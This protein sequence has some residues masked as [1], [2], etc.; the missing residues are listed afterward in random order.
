MQLRFFLPDHADRTTGGHAYD[1]RMVEAL[2]RMG[3]DAAIVPV[4][5]RLPLAD[6]AACDAAAAA[7]RDCPSPCIRVIDGS[8]LAAF[9]PL[10]DALGATQMAGLIHHPTSLEAGFD[11][12][13]HA[14]LHA[15]EQSILPRLA[16]VVTTSETV[17]ETLVDRFG[18]ARTR[19]AVVGPGVD[20]AERSTGSG[21]TQCRI[22]S[23]SA[24]APRKG[25]DVLLRAL[26]RLFDLDWHLTIVGTP[27]R[28]AA[29]AAALHAL[30]KELG[31]AGRVVFAGVVDDAALEALWRTSDLFALATHWES[32]PWAAMQALRHGVPPVIGAGG[33]AADGVTLKN[34]LVVPPGDVE[35]LS[36]ALRRAI[37]DRDLRATMA[38]EAWQNGAALP[39]WSAQAERLVAALDATQ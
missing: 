1:R 39:D 26:A 13:D 21:T 6:A 2:R 31:I 27:E 15:T 11:E 10:A 9:L 4:R 35:Q 20:P 18:V 16:R 17:A 33:A 5:G 25:H 28:H 38:A 36:K 23:V 24:L 3:H 8:A 19:I 14:R 29:H 34:G 30:A 22:L 32:T 7:W 37:F 12:A